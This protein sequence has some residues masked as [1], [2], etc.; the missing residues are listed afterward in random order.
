MPSQKVLTNQNKIRNREKSERIKQ[1]RQIEPQFWITIPRK[2][3][4]DKTEVT[5][6]P[7]EV[8]REIF[9][10][11]KRLNNKITPDFIPKKQCKKR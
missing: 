1:R 6:L 9:Q 5:V 8:D 3:Q 10:M 2:N 4:R 7:P 11:N